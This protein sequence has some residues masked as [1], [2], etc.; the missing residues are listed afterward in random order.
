MTP[1]SQDDQPRR[2]GRA[3]LM[4]SKAG[5][6]MFEVRDQD[7]EVVAGGGGYEDEFEALE[8]AQDAFPDFDLEAVIPTDAGFMVKSGKAPE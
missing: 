2:K 5:H 7:D 1:D 8:A 4:R 3:Y 6:W